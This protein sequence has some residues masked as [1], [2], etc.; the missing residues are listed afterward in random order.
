MLWSV[1]TYPQV[2]LN[3]NRRSTDG[4]STIS[5]LITIC[6]K[7]F[8]FIST[9]GLD[10]PIQYV[11]MAYFSSTAG[12]INGFQV[13]VQLVCRK[14]VCVCVCVCVCERESINYLL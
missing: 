9:Y 8:D 14:L 12:L 1:E 13:S 5:V 4:Q 2:I 3:L 10:L 11:I 7:T 6:G